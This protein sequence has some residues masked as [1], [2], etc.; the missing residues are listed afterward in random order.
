[1]R[2]LR[3]G[4]VL[5]AGLDPG[6]PLLEAVAADHDQLALLNTERDARRLGGLHD[7][8]SLVVSHAVDDIE[9]ALRRVAGE[10][11]AGNALAEVGLPLGVFDSDDLHLRIGLHGFTEAGAAA[12]ADPLLQRAGDERDLAPVAAAILQCLQRRYAG[13]TAQLDMVFADEAEVQVLRAVT[14]RR[15]D[16]DHRDAGLLGAGQRRYDRLLGA[17]DNGQH[18][19]LAGN[20]VV[21][22]LRLQRSIEM[23]A[24]RIDLHAEGVRARDKGLGQRG[25]EWM[26]RGRDEKRD[27]LAGRIGIHFGGDQ[28]RQAKCSKQSNT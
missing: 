15:V 20:G 28:E 26:R 10:Q 25:N 22:L 18:V 3:A 8:G 17:G 5:L 6:N 4:A 12:R 9:P 16:K 2:D 23:L 21:D 27:L 14:R 24:D 7:G 13:N 11:L 1:G 19:E